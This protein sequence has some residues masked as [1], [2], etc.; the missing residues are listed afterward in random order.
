VTAQLTGKECEVPEGSS[1]P[2]SGVHPLGPA[3]PEPA[4][5]LGWPCFG[6][7]AEVRP[8]FGAGFGLTAH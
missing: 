2:R 5:E 8:P 3:C 6:E 4:A 1:Q 7:K